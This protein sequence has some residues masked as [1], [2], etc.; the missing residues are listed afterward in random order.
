LTSFLETLKERALRAHRRLVLSEGDDERVRDA[1]RAMAAAGLAEVTLLG[2]EASASWA[3]RHAPGVSVRTPESDPSL[4]AVAG[5]LAARKP[6]KVPDR[7]AGFALARDPL[8]FAAGLVA[9]GEADAT[10]GGAA[11]TTADVLRAA[12]WAVGPGRRHQ[13]RFELLLHGDAGGR[14]ADLRGLRR[15]AIPDG[16]AAGRDRGGGRAGPAPGRG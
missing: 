3:F 12:L 7:S 11:H 13:D 6:E 15:G 14:S 2:G 8:R 10:V 5:L 1:A 9:L 16:G 4:G